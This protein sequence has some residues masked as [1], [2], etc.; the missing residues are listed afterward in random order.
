[1]KPFTSD[2]IVL[3]IE[4]S[5]D[6]TS[7]AVYEGATLKSNIISS[8]LVHTDFGGIV[9]ELASRAHIQNIAP[10]V[11]AALR[12][13]GLGMRAIAAIAVTQQPGLAGSLTVGANFAK[14]LAVR[15]GLPIVP[16]NHIE[17][18]IFSA[19][20]ENEDIH[21][22]FLALVV[23]GGHTSLFLVESFEQY[24]VIGSTRDD[25]AGEAFDKIAK[26]LG[27]GYP[28]GIQ[29]DTLA[30]E[31]NPKAIAFPRGMMREDHFDFSFS[32]LKT[33][34]RLYV[35]EALRQN[36]VLSPEAV[37]DICASAQEAIAEVLV[38]KTMKAVQRFGVRDIVVAGGVAANSRLRSL[39][40]EQAARHNVHVFI[41]SMKFCTD[42]AA[43]I[44][45]IGR[46]KLLRNPLHSYDAL[47]FR[48]GSN[49][50][51]AKY[52]P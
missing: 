51:R 28:G 22:P 46:E 3:A 31:G 35:Q 29:V 42:N 26:L 24:S 4:S 27:L 34:V 23:S 47:T 2:S 40:S 50:L 36:V 25:A 16:V 33:A 43:M 37:R 1:M 15:Y 21:F 45:C 44:G 7:A 20:I 49:A 32:G 12:D 38:H 41:P 10:V 52:R 8:Q 14:G 30:R 19:F 48:V 6:E 17:G 18:H 9:P 13:A 39:L 11:Q 5:C